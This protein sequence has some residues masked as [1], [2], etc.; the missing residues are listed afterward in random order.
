MVY[1]SPESQWDNSSKFLWGA[2]DKP[3]SEMIPQQVVNDD[4]G[5]GSF[6]V[7]ELMCMARIAVR[8]M[9]LVSSSS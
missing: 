2:L 3:Y 4:G 8:V 7:V 5:R 1:H 6:A 9:A